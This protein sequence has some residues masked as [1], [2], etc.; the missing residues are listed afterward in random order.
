M[1][2]TE[3]GGYWIGIPT[4]NA[5]DPAAVAGLEALM[6][7]IEAKA[8]DIRGARYFVIDLRGNSGGNTYAALRVLNAIWGQGAQDRCQGREAARWRRAST[9]TSPT[10]LRS[11]RSCS[12]R[13]A[14]HPRPMSA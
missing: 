8:A 3:D 2:A 14:S 12:V 7:D 13:L 10:S 4:L 1:R 5:L 9:T 11:N 6:K